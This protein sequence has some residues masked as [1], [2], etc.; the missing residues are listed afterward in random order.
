MSWAASDSAR[1]WATETSLPSL[2]LASDL[3]SRSGLDGSFL[4]V[5]V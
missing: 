2:A 5:V 3:K 4:V 1:G